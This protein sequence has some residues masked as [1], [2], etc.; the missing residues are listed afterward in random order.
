MA[1]MLMPSTNR[2]IVIIQMPL[3]LLMLLLLLALVP[4]QRGECEFDK[5]K[6]CILDWRSSSSSLA[7]LALQCFSCS[8]LQD[9]N[10][11]NVALLSQGRDVQGC[12]DLYYACTTRVTTMDGFSFIGRNCLPKGICENT[13]NIDGEIEDRCVTCD[14][15]F[16]NTGS[17]ASGGSTSARVMTMM[18]GQVWLLCAV[19]FTVVRVNWLWVIITD[20]RAVIGV[21]SIVIP[22]R[23][24]A[25]RRRRPV[26][27]SW[28]SHIFGCVWNLD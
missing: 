3:V 26:V 19:L 11:W 18:G 7:V 13:I 21:R 20:D 12:E 22:V 6:L 15:D 16:C 24:Q 27:A 4:V 25:S 28:R 23:N 14:T 9:D 2:R 8:S 5:N 1:Q 17:G 10:C